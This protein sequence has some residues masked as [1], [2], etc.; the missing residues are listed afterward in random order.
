LRVGDVHL[1][2]VGLEPDPR[3]RAISVVS[4]AGIVE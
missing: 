2:A 3:L 4:H 1:A